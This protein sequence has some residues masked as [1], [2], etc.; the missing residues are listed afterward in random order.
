MK[1]LLFLVALALSSTAL[2]AYSDADM[3][4]VEDS[5]DKCPNTPFTDLVDI[6]GC[7]VKKIKTSQTTQSHYDIIIGGSYAGSNYSSLNR[8]DTYSASLQADYYYGNF[9]LQASTSYYT[10]QGSNYSDT[11]LNDSF[12][13]AAYTLRPT[14][15]FYV[16]LGVGALL[17]TYDTT[18]NNNEADYMGSINVSYTVGKVNLFGG[19]VYTM[20]NDTDVVDNNVSYQY[21]NTSGYSAG[22]GY[23]VTNSF[24]LSASYN[25]SNSIY[26]SIGG[27]AVDDIK[28]A[29]AY[30][31]YSINRNYFMT[32]SYAYGLSDSASDHAGSVKLG[33]YF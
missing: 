6:N 21:H 17:P 14:S 23:Y 7:T 30:G 24:Y 28:T 15:S 9:S 33:Y 12:V 32:F 1:K 2:F 31:Y 25:Q 8:T 20:I 10:T 19:Y 11:G 27:S 29:S 4:G 13:G 26:K 16:R 5:S 3:D 18:L 22:L